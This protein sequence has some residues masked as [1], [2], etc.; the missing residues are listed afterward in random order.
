M[1]KMVT[2][3]N[4]L[5]AG[6]AN[7]ITTS[8]AL[9]TTGI[10][11]GNLGN[12]TMPVISSVTKVEPTLNAALLASRATLF[13]LATGTLFGNPNPHDIETGTAVRLVP[14]AKA[15]RNPDKRLVRLPKGFDT[16][17]KYY[18][19]APG[20]NLYPENFSQNSTKQLLQPKQV[21]HRLL[22]LVL[23]VAQHQVHIVL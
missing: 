11:N 3:E 10:N 8:I 21:V 7:Q 6:I 18:V 12:K 19:I 2:S 22:H 17:T 9:I 23:L 16:N 15:G 4:P 14:K 20:R 13:S 1:I 5:C